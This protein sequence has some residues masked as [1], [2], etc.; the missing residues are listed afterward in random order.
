MLFTLS[1]LAQTQ[2]H[3]AFDKVRKIQLKNGDLYGRKCQKGVYSRSG[4]VGEY[5]EYRSKH[6][7]E[8]T[9]AEDRS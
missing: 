9:E 3:I 6:A 2:R 1:K 8:G 4:V 5:T 7:T